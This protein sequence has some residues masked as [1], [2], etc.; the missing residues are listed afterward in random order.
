[1]KYWT[2]LKEDMGVANLAFVLWATGKLPFPTT[3]RCTP[4]SV[5]SA[6]EALNN[7]VDTK[8][9]A[10]FVTFYLASVERSNPEPWNP[11]SRMFFA[12]M[13]CFFLPLLRIADGAWYLLKISFGLWAARTCERFALLERADVFGS[14]ALDGSEEREAETRSAVLANIGRTNTLVFCMLP[15]LSFLNKLAEFLNMYPVWVPPSF[16]VVLTDNRV[17]NLMRWLSAV[18]I[19]FGSAAI[20]FQPIPLIGYI[21]LFAFFFLRFVE[22]V[23]SLMGSSDDKKRPKDA[24]AGLS[25]FSIGRAVVNHASK[26]IYDGNQKVR[27]LAGQADLARRMNDARQLFADR[28]DSVVTSMSTEKSFMRKND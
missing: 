8:W 6:L 21:I 5:A 9:Y 10:C 19:M 17:P 14:S 27:Q 22:L 15:G 23:V 18:T 7:D 26:I 1:M 2:I 4:S 11:V 24:E 12:L 25:M 3:D 28:A 20:I 13:I 16:N